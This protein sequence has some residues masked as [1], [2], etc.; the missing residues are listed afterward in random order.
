MKYSSQ[1]WSFNHFTGVD[2]NE[3]GGK[4]AIFKI[5]GDN[6]DWA[7]NVDGENGN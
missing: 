5:Q 6:K 1:K 7:Q 4:K 2:Y 3:D